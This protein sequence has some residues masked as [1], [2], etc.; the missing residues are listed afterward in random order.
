M[1][2]FYWQKTKQTKIINLRQNQTNRKCFKHQFT[3][4]KLRILPQ[5]RAFQKFGFHLNN[6]SNF[7]PTFC[8]F[9]NCLSTKLLLVLKNPTNLGKNHEEKRGP[10]RWSS[11]PCIWK[12]E[13]GNI[14]SRCL[15]HLFPV[16]LLTTLLRKYIILFIIFVL[17]SCYLL[18]NLFIAIYTKVYLSSQEWMQKMWNRFFVEG[19]L[20]RLFL[21]YL[22]TRLF[23]KEENMVGFS[24]MK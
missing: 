14:P 24:S 23:Q 12:Q 18:W 20:F 16:T 1:A 8:L 21:I 9:S 15:H 11:P 5:D 2:Y 4:T 3:Q 17:F 10:E 7:L 13:I 19:L 6:D 22:Q